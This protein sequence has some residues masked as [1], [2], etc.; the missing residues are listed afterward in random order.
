MVSYYDHRTGMV[1]RPTVLLD[2]ETDDAHDN[3]VLA[4][5]GEGYVWVFSNSH[6]V[7]RPSYIRRQN[8]AHGRRRSRA[9]ARDLRA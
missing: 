9:N 6:G 2:K 5:D 1:P 8:V 3:P 7:E 4:I